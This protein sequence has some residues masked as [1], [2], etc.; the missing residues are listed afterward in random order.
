MLF[1]LLFQRR[2]ITKVLIIWKRSVP[3]RAPL[4][5][6]GLILSILVKT[7]QTITRYYLVF[8]WHKNYLI[9]LQ[10]KCNLPLNQC[11]SFSVIET[12]IG[13]VLKIHGQALGLN[14]AMNLRAFRC[15]L[16]CKY[17]RTLHPMKLD[18]IKWGQNL[19]LL[20]N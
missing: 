16:N 6:I 9:T 11:I 14:D 17:I 5:V 15:Q 2:P 8:Q 19:L 7:D 12:K 10:D 20:G 13:E 18:V 4:F 3:S 1:V